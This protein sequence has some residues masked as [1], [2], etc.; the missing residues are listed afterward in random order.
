V[1]HPRLESMIFKLLPVAL[2]LANAAGI[3]LFSTP[4]RAGGDTVHL[5]AP[6]QQTG[7]GQFIITTVSARNDL[8]SGDSAL[9]RVSVATALALT[10]IGVYL[11]N[12]KVT[13]SFIETP[14]GSHVLQGLVK[15]LRRGDNTLLVRDE[16]NQSN[17]SQLVLTNYA[18]TG[19]ILSGPHITPYECRTTQNGLGNPLDA[20]CSAA[21]KISYYYRSN[22]NSFR[23]LSRPTGPYPTDLVN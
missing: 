14:I 8:I 4:V 1:I 23:V 22:A 17:A 10:Q 20:D 2:S 12:T 9:V 19:P 5:T 18:I 13:S 3:G 6:H 16:R 7:S 15:S 21:T 11:N